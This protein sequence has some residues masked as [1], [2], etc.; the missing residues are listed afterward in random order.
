LSGC[1]SVWTY[2]DSR[3]RPKRQDVKALLDSSC[4]IVLTEYAKK[5]RALES[6]WDDMYQKFGRL[7]GRMDRQRAINAP[8]PAEDSPPPVLPRASRSDILRNR[9]VI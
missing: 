1:I 8:A 2:L 6:E 7:A 9:R 5:F 3:E 4:E